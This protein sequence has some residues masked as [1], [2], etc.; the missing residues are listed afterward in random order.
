MI[1]IENA[2]K[3]ALPKANCGDQKENKKVLAGWNDEVKYFQESAQ[4]LFAV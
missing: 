3:T 4:F 2:C 1:S